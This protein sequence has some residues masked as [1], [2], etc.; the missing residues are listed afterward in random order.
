[1]Y[2][3]I[4]RK[5]LIVLVAILTTIFSHGQ[6]ASSTFYEGEELLKKGKKGKAEVLFEEALK[7]AREEKNTSVEMMCHL[8]LAELKNNLFD[9]KEALEHYRSFTK[10]YRNKLMEENK[11]LN[12]EVGSLTNEVSLREAQIDSNKEEIVRKSDTINQLSYEQLK[13]DLKLQKLKNANQLTEMR[14]EKENHQTRLMGLFIGFLVVVVAF[15]VVIYLRKRRSNQLLRVKNNEISQE[16]AKSDGLLLNILPP[17]VAEE[18]K[19]RGKTRSM[20]FEQATVMFTDFEGFTT[21]SGDNNPEEVVKMLDFYFNAFDQIISQYHIEKIKT[22]GDAYL[23]VSGLPIANPN[24][25]E[26]MVHAAID[27]QRF[28]K[29]NPLSRFGIKDHHMEMRIGLHSG[30]V[31]AGVVGSKKF[32]YDVW[33]D[34]VNVAARMEQAGEGG[35]INVSETV[36]EACGD[37]FMF[38]YRGEIEAKNKGKLKMYFV[39]FE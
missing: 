8:E 28:V 26:D 6:I 18:L 10:L 38:T 27:F 31:V 36:A 20:K 7:Q 2:K 9:Y 34:T 37:Q 25:V 1:M 33:G 23:C 12:S 16:K 29:E 13:S 39:E 4:I 15:V 35:K 17:V 30:P 24:H 22:I 5:Y 19:K 14:L 21:F 3:H 32:A 11:R